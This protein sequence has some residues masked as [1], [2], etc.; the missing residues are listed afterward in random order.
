[1]QI[2][3]LMITGG[4]STNFYTSQAGSRVRYQQGS[5]VIYAVTVEDLLV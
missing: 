5:A 1:V 4:K 2:K 3:N